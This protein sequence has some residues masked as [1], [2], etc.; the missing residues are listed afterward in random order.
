MASEELKDKT[1][2]I[3]IVGT[4]GVYNQA[5]SSPFSVTFATFN[6]I[7]TWLKVFFDT[8]YSQLFIDNVV[9]TDDYTILD[10]DTEVMYI[11]KGAGADK[12]FT[13][14]TLADN[15]GKTFSVRNDDTTYMLTADGEGAETIDGMLTIQLPKPGNYIKVFAASDEWKIIG[16]SITSQLRLN[17]YAGYGSTDTKIMRFT[18]VVENVGNMFSENHVSGYSGNTKGLEIL[19]NRRKKYSINFNSNTG[20]AFGLTLNSSQLTTGLNAVTISTVLSRSEGPSGGYSSAAPSEMSFNDSDTIR[21]HT[22]GA[23][24][25]SAANVFFTITYIGD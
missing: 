11:L 6:T 18:N 8:L 23:A 5:N 21:P 3:S 15:Q 1:E 14:P 24:P 12:T 25:T 19:L 17:T 13:L 22:N 16:E 9:K 7:K 4:E 2:L 20:D 10:S